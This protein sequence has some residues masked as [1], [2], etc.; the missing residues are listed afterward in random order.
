MFALYNYPA[1]HSPNIHNGN[2]LEYRCTGLPQGQLILLMV[3][4]RD[5]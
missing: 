2:Q 5:A 4:V 3:L 1:L